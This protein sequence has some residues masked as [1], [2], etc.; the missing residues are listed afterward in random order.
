MD[1]KLPILMYHSIQ[2][3]PRNEVMKSLHVHPKAFGRQMWLLNTLGYKAMGLSEAITSKQQHPE[4]KIVALTFDDGYENFHTN[5]LPILNEYGFKAT[6]F[7]L[8]DHISGTNY[9]DHSLGI[10]PNPLMNFEQ[11][12]HCVSQGIE[13]GSHGCRHLDLT[14][15]EA[16]QAKFEIFNSKNKL[17]EALNIKINCFCYPY[18]SKTENIIKMA[19]LAEYGL[20]VSMSRSACD[21]AQ[22]HRH[23]LPR[24]P[25]NWRTTLPQL[26]LKIKT[27]Y[28][29]RHN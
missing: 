7:I 8:S 12:T 17:E 22:H 9:W 20:A 29:N 24:I 25:I 23:D 5:A 15:I 10:S 19:E 13:I 4:S 2:D 26:F 21:L 11:I 27:N 6:V 16:N 1:Q 3:V 14:K 18:G 28:E